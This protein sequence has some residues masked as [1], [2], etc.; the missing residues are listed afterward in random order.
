MAKVTKVF[1]FKTFPIPN[2]GVWEKIGVEAELEIGE[3]A[4]K[5]L[6]DCKKTVENFHYEN[7]KADEKK[8]EVVTSIITYDEKIPSTLT[9]VASIIKD[10]NTCQELK[11][12]ESYRLI[13]KSDPDI[14]DAYNKKLRELMPKPNLKQ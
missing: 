5:A 10:I 12:L 11:V 2:L 6:Y 3:D 1:Y 14:Q 13:A 4:R 8:K 9:Q 7:N